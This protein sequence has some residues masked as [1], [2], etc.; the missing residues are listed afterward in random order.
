MSTH[1]GDDVATGQRARK[2]QLDVFEVRAS[3]SLRRASEVVAF[4][5]WL[6]SKSSRRAADVLLP[7]IQV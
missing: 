1:S 3:E 2:T 5:T 6:P 7:C 4:A